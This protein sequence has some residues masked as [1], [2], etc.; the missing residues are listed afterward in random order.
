MV[1]ATIFEPYNRIF[2]SF[3]QWRNQPNS[4]VQHYH[5]TYEIYLQTDG[6]RYLFL[7]DVCHILKKGDLYILTPFVIHYTRSGSLPFSDRYV[8]NFTTGNLTPL[9]T[10]EEAV[11]LCGNLHTGV[12]HL[13][14]EQYLQLLKIFEVFCSI[15]GCNGPAKGN[16]EEKA[17]AGCLLCLLTS[18][19][20]SLQDK[21]ITG[22]LCVSPANLQPELIDAIHFINYHYTEPITL[23]DVSAHIH[24]SKYHFCRLFRQ[25]TGATFLEYLYNVRLSKVHILL[26]NTDLP[27][28]EIAAKAGFRSTAH[29]SRCFKAVYHISPRQMRNTQQSGNPS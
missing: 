4:K 10:S 7:D 21:K 11:S 28:S 24:M 26:Q 27:L 14:E 13:P 15:P 22:E 19:N 23:D 6:E 2:A 16:L 3:A 9:L 25:F 5:D 17:K 20:T 29:L 12:Y 8:T 18:L 1:D